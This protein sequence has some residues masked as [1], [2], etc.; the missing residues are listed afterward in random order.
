MMTQKVL[1]LF[2]HPSQHRSEV[3]LPLFDVAK[4]V[5]GV[6]T[7]D[8][9]AEYPTFNINI[10]RE[11][12]RLREHDVI[13]FQFPLYWYSTPAI[14][15]EWQDLVLEY[16]FA[17]GTGGDALVDKTFFCSLTAGAK[18]DAYRA[19]GYNHFTIRQ[20][21]YPL[22]QMASLTGMYYLPPLALF[23]SRTAL[24]ENRIDNHLAEWRHLLQLLV[25]GD[26]DR[27][28]AS[29][30]EKLNH[31]LNDDPRMMEAVK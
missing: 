20:L 24:E 1:V 30:L 14:L 8:L 25:A 29:Q 9:Y 3:N 27:E 7:V 13:I 22:E 31:Y 17:Y 18:V 28:R 23:G 11:Q 2:A 19:E 4:K 16:T 6:T 5:S 15:K 26:L 12:K 10:D 21:L